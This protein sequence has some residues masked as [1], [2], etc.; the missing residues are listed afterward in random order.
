MNLS[1]AFD[2]DGHGHS[3]MLDP[4]G[5]SSHRKSV[6]GNSQVQAALAGAK[7]PSNLSSQSLHDFLEQ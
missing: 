1:G 4:D 3:E 7:H 2:C 5:T 6:A